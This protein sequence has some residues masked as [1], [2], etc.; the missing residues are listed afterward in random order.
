MAARR[1]ATEESQQVIRETNKNVTLLM[2][3]HVPHIYEALKEHDKTLTSIQSDVRAMDTKLDAQIE[4]L[5]DTKSAIHVL[6]DSFIRHLESSTKDSA[7]VIVT[8]PKRRK[9]RVH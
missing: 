3:N 7:P 1:K 2:E 8:V 9:A 6:G 5:N 4:R